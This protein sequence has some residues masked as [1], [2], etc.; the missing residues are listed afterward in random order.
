MTFQQH[1][2]GQRRSTV[3]ESK[4]VRGCYSLA[5]FSTLAALE[6]PPSSDSVDS[7][8]HVPKTSLE[9]EMPRPETCCSEQFRPRPSMDSLNRW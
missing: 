4:Q 3:P 1:Q 5:P 6:M 8:S 2:Q 9:P 7:E